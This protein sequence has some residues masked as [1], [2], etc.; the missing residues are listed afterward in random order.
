MTND[1]SELDL[2]YYMVCRNWSDINEH[3]P[4]LSK[5]ASQSQSVIELGVRNGVSSWGFLHGLMKN[6]STIKKMLMVDIEPCNVTYF[7]NIANN[8]PVDVSYVW[9]NDL[10]VDIQ[11]TWDLT[12]I[13]TWH[14]Y[15]QLKR[16][17]NKYSKVTN[18]YI[19]MHDTEVDAVY[20]ETL[21]C[22]MNAQQ[23]SIQSGIPVDEITKGLMPAL[24]EFLAS[25]PEWSI[26]AH[27][28]NCNGLTVLR[29]QGIVDAVTDNLIIDTVL[30]SVNVETTATIDAT[31]TNDIPVVDPSA[32]PLIT[33][34]INNA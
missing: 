28:K 14:V 19:I 23:Q 17:L 2:E 34:Q 22:G 6:G 5:Y 4:T 32:D 25:N 16:E 10:D 1:T 15:G 29:K 3:V 21:R 18:K 20:G 13:D 7:M 30:P 26:E 11:G 33:D 12:F 27:Y 24:V 8:L 31:V 9:M